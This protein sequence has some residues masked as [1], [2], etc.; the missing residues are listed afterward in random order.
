MHVDTL[1]NILQTRTTDPLKTRQALDNFSCSIMELKD[2]L[3]TDE[4]QQTHPAAD[5]AG[6]AA[7]ARRTRPS[8][9]SNVSESSF[10]VKSVTF[11]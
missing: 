9:I 8:D 7:T 2:K 10:L 4:A 3:T 11:I 6:A 1:Y 5:T